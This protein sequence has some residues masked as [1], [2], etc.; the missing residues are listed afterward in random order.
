MKGNRLE[1]L[2]DARI[3]TAYVT[4]EKAGNPEYNGPEKG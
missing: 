4:I 2:V 3:I 1:T